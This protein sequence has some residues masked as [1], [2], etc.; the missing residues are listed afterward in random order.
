MFQ[1]TSNYLALIHGTVA[2]LGCGFQCP[3]NKLLAWLCA[4]L[5]NNL[6]SCNTASSAS[7]LSSRCRYLVRGNLMCLRVWTN[8][9]FQILALLG[10]L[11]K[12]LMYWDSK[13][14]AELLALRRLR[15]HYPLYCVLGEQSETSY[16]WPSVPSGKLSGNLK[17]LIHSYSP[18]CT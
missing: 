13:C 18:C 6:T 8:S 3:L 15:P 2:V 16:R 4:S 14:V 12:Y 9:A 11:L 10:H 5:W 1:G 17:L 7:V